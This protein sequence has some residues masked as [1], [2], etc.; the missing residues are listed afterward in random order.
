[1]KPDD[2]NELVMILVSG[3][4]ELRFEGVVRLA[5]HKCSPGGALTFY[6]DLFQAGN[7]C[8]TFANIRNIMDLDRS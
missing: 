8:I 1:M 6:C 7:L 5:H 3:F 2:G 4:S